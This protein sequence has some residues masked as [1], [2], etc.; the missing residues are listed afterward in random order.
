MS[1]T[2]TGIF[3]FRKDLR[4]YDNLGLNELINKCHTIIPIFILDPYQIDKGEHNKYYRS[5][6]FIIYMLSCID[7]LNKSLD[8]RLNIYH[9]SV[10]NVLNKIIK[11]EDI[12]YICFNA[13]YTRYAIE[14]DTKIQ[15]IC[16]KN[17]IKCIINHQDQLLYS[18]DRGLKL[19]KEPYMLFSS[20]YKN[21]MLENPKA[22]VLIT[23]NNFKK[24]NTPAIDFNKFFERNENIKKVLYKRDVVLK[25]IKYHTLN[26]D[27][28]LIT[29]NYLISTALSLG[30]VS[31]RE[32]YYIASSDYLKKTLYWRDYFLTLLRYM[33][34]AN[35]YN[36]SA[37]ERYDKVVWPPLHKNN[38]KSFED[39]KTGFLLIDAIHTELKTT[40]YISNRARLLIGY[41]WIKLLIINPYD[42]KYG[43]ISGFSKHLIDCST[44]Q[45]NLNHMWTLSALDISGRRFCKK[46]TNTLTGRMMNVD[47]SMIKKYDPECTYIKKFLPHLKDI[48]NKDLYKWNEKM[49]TT[50]NN[51]HCGYIFDVKVQYTKYTNLFKN[52]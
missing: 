36:L 51:I 42:K 26:N 30:V 29:D 15:N 22:P 10:E 31:E 37:F 39:C 45:N 21:L 12:D 6:N 4:K 17:K 2:G 46:G 19:N 38:W 13:D 24:L 16:D 43:S 9:D 50:Y 32:V 3:I 40:G 5:N 41:F 49:N 7:E 35:E 34:H 27:D 20:F 48:P 18:F 47:N 28:M 14:R 8:D 33:P 25:H 44:S 23:F 52:I 11:K 1:K